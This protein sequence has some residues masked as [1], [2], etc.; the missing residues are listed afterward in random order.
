MET[1]ELK[2]TPPEG[3]EIDESKSTFKNI[4][5]K[6]VEKE[7]PKSWEEIE[8]I[9]GYYI[10]NQSNIN[11][12]SIS[13]CESAKN[14]FVTLE[15]ANASLALAQLS[16]L[17]NVYNDGWK[18]DWTKEYNKYCI[19][20]CEDKIKTVVYC[21]SNTFLAFKSNEIRTKFLEKFKDLIEQAKP[22]L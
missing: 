8:N 4:V 12:F 20:I 17:M 11:K 13:N 9:L 14:T 10:N 3:F 21:S 5:F 6:E 22:L 19:E 2:I 7:L 1:K 18:P 16:Q 15:Q